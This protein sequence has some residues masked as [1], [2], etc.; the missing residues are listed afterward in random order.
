MHR[1]AVDSDRHPQVQTAGGELGPLGVTQCRAHRHCS[2]DG[3][4]L[5][6]G[7][8]EEQEERVTTELEQ[9]A[10]LLGGDGEHAGKDV[11]QDLGQLLGSNPTASRETL[12]Q[13]R[14]AGDVDEAQRGVDLAPQPPG[15]AEIP[16][17]RRSGQERVEVA[18]YRSAHAPAPPTTPV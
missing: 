17:D 4:H 14:E 8:G 1:P 6:V 3:A 11:V 12:G 7:S 5:V 15:R 2:V 9:A 16:F 18:D 10:S 13:G